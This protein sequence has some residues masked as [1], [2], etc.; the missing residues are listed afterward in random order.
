MIW[1]K[2]YFDKYWNFNNK[3]FIDLLKNAQKKLKAK[4]S[5]SKNVNIEISIFNS[6]SKKRIMAIYKQTFNFC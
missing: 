6:V 1:D 4:R 3:D 2:Q 5:N